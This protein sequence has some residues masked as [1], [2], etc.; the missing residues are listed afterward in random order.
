E[1]ADSRPLAALSL[2]MWKPE[3]YS[4][5]TIRIF[6]GAVVWGLGY[7]VSPVPTRESTDREV[8]RGLC[9]PLQRARPDRGLARTSEHG[10][11]KP[12]AIAGRGAGAADGD[13]RNPARHL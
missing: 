9:E 11:R 7:E 4:R 2:T 6:T 13:G 12:Q 3:R 1:R 10:G 8:L 5:F